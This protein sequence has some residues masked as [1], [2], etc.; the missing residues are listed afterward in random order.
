MTKRLSKYIDFFDY[1]EKSL[2]VLSVTSGSISI[3]SFVNVIGEPV[4]IAS[5]SFSLAFSISI[6]IL[7]I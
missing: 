4:G 3:I 6:G 1:F 7:Y 5:A 2:V